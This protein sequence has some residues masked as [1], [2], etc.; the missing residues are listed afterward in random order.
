MLKLLIAIVGVGVG[1]YLL[2][3]R[4]KEKDSLVAYMIERNKN[5]AKQNLNSE[6][7]ELIMEKMVGVKKAAVENSIYNRHIDAA[8]TMKLSVEKIRE[9]IRI[10]NDLDNKIDQ[11]SGELDKM[12][13]ED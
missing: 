10:S 12:L 7:S 8:E 11:L 5:I 3:N 1:I 4:Q 13:S 2:V 6:E 9:N